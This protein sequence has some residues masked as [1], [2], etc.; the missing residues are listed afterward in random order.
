MDIDHDK[1]EK[2]HVAVHPNKNVDVNKLTI[3]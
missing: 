2:M 3:F 1:K